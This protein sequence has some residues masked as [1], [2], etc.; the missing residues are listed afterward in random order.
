MGL[1]LAC[2]VGCEDPG[3]G[4][5]SDPLPEE[6]PSEPEPPESVPNVPA[7]A[8]DDGPLLAL[9]THVDTPQLS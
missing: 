2:V 7:E 6:P 5:E 1:T 8:P 9:D 4:A 3:P